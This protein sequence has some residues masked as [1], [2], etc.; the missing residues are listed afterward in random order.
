MIHGAVLA[1]VLAASG[2]ARAQQAT[3]QAAE[4]GDAESTPVD[5]PVAQDSPRASLAQYLE[6]C[7]AS[8]Y[9]DAS[10]YLDLS[11]AEKSRGPELARRLKAVLD[12][13]A[14]FD[15]SLISPHPEGNGEDRLP[16]GVDEIAQIPGP[17]GLPE[18]VR[19][20]RRNIEG[21]RWV[22][23]SATV[24][25]I[26]TW[27]A[28]LDHHWLLEHLPTALLRPGPRDLLY[29]QWLAMPFL[30][31][32]ALAIGY[33]ANRLSRR[34][35]ARI[36]MR[37]ATRWDDEVLERIGGPLTF[38]WAL[39]ATYAL[40]PWLGLYEPAEEFVYRWLRGGF[41]LVF[42][43]TLARSI[44]IT[45]QIIAES[46]WAVEHPASRS[47]LPLGA[48]VAKV[49]ILAI[50]IVALL[51]ELGYSIASLIAGFG[52]GGLAVALAAQKTVENLFGAFS[53]SADQPF[54]EGDFVRI[55]DFVGTVEAIGLRSTRVRTLD[56][57]VISIPNGKLAEMRLESYAARDRIRLACTIGVVYGTTAVQM[58]EV[59]AEFERVLREHPKIWPEPADIVVRFKEF[60]ASSLD[61]EVMAW[62]QTQDFNEFRAIRQDVLLQFMDVVEKAGSSFA[63]PTRTVHLVN[64][65]D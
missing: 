61:I 31:L 18:P 36:V 48:R 8:R 49:L 9:N 59:L 17:A 37:T 1:C 23:S 38:A 35:L 46:P 52:I 57:T 20:V 60:G 50:A 25:R 11:R 13:Y 47:L 62:F 56:R 27:Y 7:R 5:E 30:L 19:L 65:K 40:L 44:D 41:F 6:L 53:I 32:F 21:G 22:F 42:F 63:F 34:I 39:A 12:R 29:W 2:T 15:L 55:E 64:E 3:D 24:N 16:R 14:W 28:R 4:D 51:S 45:R 26:D 43:W 54:R 58:R 33:V 10:G